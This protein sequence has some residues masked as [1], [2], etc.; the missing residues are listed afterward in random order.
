[1]KKFDTSFN[2]LL[3]LLRCPMCHSSKLL[4]MRN[5]SLETIESIRLCEKYLFCTNC[6]NQYP[7]TEDYIPI[8]WDADLRRIYSNINILSSDSFSTI[9]ANIAIYDQISDD[10]NLFTRK[11]IQICNK[12]QNSVKKIINA[13]QIKINR[14]NSQ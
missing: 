1:M 9:D 12:I 3:N 13:R 7:I 2:E 5:G 4:E 10:Y 14:A 11:N 6:E 8:M